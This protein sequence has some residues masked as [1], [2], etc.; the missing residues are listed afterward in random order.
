[1]RIITRQRRSRKGGRRL[2]KGVIFDL[3]GVL[4]ST[5]ELHY[6]AWKRLAGEIGISD[7]TKKDNEAQRGIGR[8]ESLEVLLQKTDKAYSPEE[9]QEMAF[10]KNEYYKALLNEMSP[11]SLLPG[12][13]DTLKLLKE[14]GVKLAVGSASANAPVI[15]ERIG[16]LEWLDAYSSGLDTSASKPDPEVFLIAADRLGIPPEECLVVEDAPAGIRA[17]RAG[18]MHCMGVGPLHE[19]LG[20]DFHAG[21]LSRV[22]N[23]DEVLL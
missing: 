9:K 11:Q 4:V 7:F 19:N 6:Q 21:D 23:W 13:A 5:D 16:I 14:R 15:L 17:A 20:A 18:G 1:M 22:V 8:M 3:D 2:I 12:A 10:R